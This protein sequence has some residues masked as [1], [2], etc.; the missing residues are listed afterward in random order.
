MG[1]PGWEELEEGE[2]VV[3]FG[4]DAGVGV[5][6][7]EGDGA[8]ALDE[9]E[10]GE[11]EAPGGVGGGVV[12]EA[13]VG[14]GDVDQD[15]LE[16][17]AM[18]RRNSVGD[19]EAGGEFA[20]RVGEERELEVV[21]LGGE[22]VLA[23]VLRGDGDEDGAAG[24]DGGVEV[25]PGFELGD[26]VGIP[27]AA[28]ELEDDGA[29]REEVGGADEFAGLGV[30]EREGR[31]EGA[32]WQDAIFDAAGEELGDGLLGRGE[33]VGLDE[34]AGAGGDGVETV[35]EERSHC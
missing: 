4:A 11:R 35:L 24:A 28:E 6:F 13:G 3:G 16:V 19:A 12:G 5:G 30:L 27:A 15:G 34:R 14:E 26:A 22:V 10:R 33:A 8:V 9:E 17:A 31:G 18:R 25:A 7:G 29:E 2:E 23:A 1:H 32:G 21:L 20:A